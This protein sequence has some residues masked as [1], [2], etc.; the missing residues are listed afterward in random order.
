[1]K[2]QNRPIIGH[3][4]GKIGAS[5]LSC[6]KLLAHSFHTNNPITALPDSALEFVFF[7]M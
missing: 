7:K 2:H 1:M 3:P 5:P 6:L 4:N